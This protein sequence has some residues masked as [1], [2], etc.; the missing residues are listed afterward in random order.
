LNSHGANRRARA[1]IDLAALRSNY[2]HLKQHSG[3]NHL[4]AV[5]KADAYGH[6]ALEVARALPD[7]DAFAVAALGEA[8]ALREAGITQKIL[9]LGGFIRSDELQTCIDLAGLVEN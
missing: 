8:V 4:I 6:G 1:I 2:R 3:G 7:A 5:V 9:L